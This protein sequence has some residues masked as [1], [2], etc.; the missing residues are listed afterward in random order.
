MPTSDEL[1]DRYPL[2]LLPLSGDFFALVWYTHHDGHH[3]VVAPSEAGVLSTYAALR[4]NPERGEGSKPKAWWSFRIVAPPRRCIEHAAKTKYD[5]EVDSFRCW[6]FS[7]VDEVIAPYDKGMDFEVWMATRC[8]MLRA[9]P[10]FRPCPFVDPPWFASYLAETRVDELDKVE[11]VEREQAEYRAEHSVCA[12]SCH[13]G[14]LPADG[15]WADF[16]EAHK[17]VWEEETRAKCEPTAGI[18]ALP[19][20]RRRFRDDLPAPDPDRPLFVACADFG[21]HSRGLVFEEVTATDQPDQVPFADALFFFQG[22]TRALPNA[23]EEMLADERECERQAEVAAE[24]RRGGEKQARA[25]HVK[26]L[27]SRIF[28]GAGLR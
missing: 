26:Y 13:D 17:S 4:D 3:A 15:T 11:E 18:S 7:V 23:L 1:I 5:Q 16:Y 8:E 19:E 6:L 22:E 9:F 25:A 14:L 24:V 28:L 12:G 27:F 20:E 21:H 10:F 2:K